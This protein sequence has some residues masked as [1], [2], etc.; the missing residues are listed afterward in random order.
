MKQSLCAAE[1]FALLNPHIRYTRLQ[2]G[3]ADR[4]PL[5]DFCVDSRCAGP[6]SLFIC[7]CGFFSDGHEYAHAAYHA[8]CRCFVICHPLRKAL[9]E[10]AVVYAVEDTRT[11]QAD[12]A[13]IFY[14]YPT[15][16]LRLIGITG[17]KGKTTTAMM[18]YTML[19]TL[20]VSV[21]YIGTDGVRYA[22]HHEPTKNTTPDAPELRR[23]FRDMTDNGVDTVV[24][25]IS[26]QSVWQKRLLGLRFAIGAFTNLSPDHI[27]PTEHPDFEHYFACKHAFLTDY[28][29][30]AVLLNAD[31]AHAQRMAEDVFV[32]IRYYGSGKQQNGFAD[33]LCPA[34]D[35]ATPGMAFTYWKDDKAIPVHLPLPGA[36]NVS[37]ALCALAILGMFFSKLL[38][39]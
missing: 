6:G 12:L 22:D 14:G 37:N 5:T 11:A 17:T 23:I 8:G 38:L 2:G 35:G 19:R 26:S 32:P 3:E 7:L 16:S 20:G 15:R 39:L 33:G 24:M 25:E 1:L 29:T 21:G 4:R 36:Y 31:D 30:D 9:P 34:K 13:E 27:S 28:C 18:T 10:D